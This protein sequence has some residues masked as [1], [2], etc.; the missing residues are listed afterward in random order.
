MLPRY[1]IAS[2]V[3]T[4]PERYEAAVLGSTTEISVIRVL[5]CPRCD[6]LPAHRQSTPQNYLLSLF[7]PSFLL[8]TIPHHHPPSSLLNS[9]SE[10]VLHPHAMGVGLLSPPHGL[11]LV[12]FWRSLSCSLKR[13]T[14]REI[15]GDPYL[16]GR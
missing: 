11:L 12:A 1:A 16:C 10:S 6:L 2:P 7:R 14:L 13:D 8:H 3:L 5:R 4:L 9:Y 15:N